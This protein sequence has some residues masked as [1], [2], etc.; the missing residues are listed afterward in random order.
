MGEEG[1]KIREKKGEYE[2]TIRASEN[3]VRGVKETDRNCYPST[4]S[5]ND[6][7]ANVHD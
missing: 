2:C 5:P 7:L 4:S 3:D 1:R 6:E